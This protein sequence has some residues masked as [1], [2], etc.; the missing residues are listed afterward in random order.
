MKRFTKIAVIGITASGLLAFGSS[1]IAAATKAPVKSASTTMKGSLPKGKPFQYLNSRIDSLEN[2]IDLLIGRVGSLE[3]WQ[4]K[5]QSAL[6]TLETNVTKNAAAIALLQGQ[7]ND[8]N[9]ILKTKQ[10]IINGE[11]PA[12]QY[13]YKVSP[14]EGLVCRSDVGSNGLAVLTVQKEAEILVS[15]TVDVSATCPAGSVP[16][17]GSFNAAPGLTVNSNG[18]TADGYSVN[19]TNAMTSIS[20]VSVTATCLAVN[21]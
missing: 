3:T 9:D 1:A 19:V 15:T 10:D 8:V 17:G 4:A 6:D 20:A 13:L 2:Q 12:N 16:T 21:P 5:A 18:I 14:T 7:I 11:C